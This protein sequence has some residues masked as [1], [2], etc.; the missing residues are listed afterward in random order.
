MSERDEFDAAID[1]TVHGALAAG[2]LLSL[3][4]VLLPASPATLR[5]FFLLT[6]LTCCSS[7]W[8]QYRPQRA[9]TH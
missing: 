7:I 4:L 5:G 1:V 8:Q 6:L 2:A 9:N 3:L